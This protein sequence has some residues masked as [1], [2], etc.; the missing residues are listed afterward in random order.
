M[1]EM[2]KGRAHIR[3]NKKRQTY[4]M[5]FT[6]IFEDQLE[7]IQFALSIARREAETEYDS[8][9][10]DAICQHFLATYPRD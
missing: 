2:M 10:L 1:S 6:P 4:R 5:R 8:V 7:L 3:L 9:A